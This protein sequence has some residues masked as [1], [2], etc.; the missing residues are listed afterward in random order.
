MKMPTMNVIPN[1]QHITDTFYGYNHALR[2]RDGEFYHTENLSTSHFPMC[3]TR[4][5][6]GILDISQT[7]AQGIINKDALAYV[8]NG[9]LWYN[10][11]ATPVTGLKEGEKQ[12]ISMGAYI[13]IWPDK[14]FY[15]TADPADYGGMEAHWQYSGRVTYQMCSA[16]GVI[17]PDAIESS[18]EPENPDNEDLWIDSNDGTLK[19]WSI[20]MGSWI[21]VESV[22]TKLTFTTQGQ[23]LSAFKEHDGVE[24]SG[25]YFD[26]LNGSKILYAV[27]GSS[28]TSEFNFTDAVSDYVILIGIVENRYEQSAANITISRLVPD[29]DFVCECQNRIWGCFYGNDGKQNINELYCC[30]LGDF[31]NWSQYLGVSTDSWRASVG[32]DGVWTGAVNYLGRPMFFKEDRIHMIS[33]SSVGAHQVSDTPARGVQKGSHKSLEV[34]NEIL[35]YKSRSDVC[36]YQGGFPESVSAKLG[37]ERY[38]NAVAGSYGQKYYI[39]MQDSKQKWHLFVYDI[40]RSLWIREDNLHVKQFARMNDEL[41]ALVDN[42]IYAL[43]GTEG[44]PEKDVK[45][46]AETG[47]LH[48]EHPGKKYVSRFNIRANLSP[49]TILTLYVEYDS[50]GVW[51]FAGKYYSRPNHAVTILVRP[52]RCDHLRLKIEG[53]KDAK[54]FSISRILEK[55]SDT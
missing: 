49:A 14:V 40:L 13:L 8:D 42:K 9:T 19:Q 46:K 39:S 55:G 35:F 48:Y 11:Y 20:S 41:Y 45:W 1:S 10:G 33:I 34:V 12:L 52:R 3:S 25:A 26:E 36:A 53:T 50:S 21:S 31:K 30:A 28:G 51:E 5:R 47:I 44:E 37:D 4:P 23:L 24:I 7:A 18:T 17:Y 43:N 38:Y 22:Y 15:N 32:T 54:L 29:M 27:G 6:R 2:I 16:D